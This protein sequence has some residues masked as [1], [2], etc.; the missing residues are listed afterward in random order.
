MRYSKSGLI[1]ITKRKENQ[2]K[3]KFNK[4]Y[5][6]IE[7]LRERKKKFNFSRIKKNHSRN[8]IK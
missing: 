8:G 2:Q 4:K 3:K 1:I 7:R 5:K 6:N